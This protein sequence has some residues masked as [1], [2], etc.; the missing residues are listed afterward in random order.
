M[1]ARVS[2]SGPFTVIAFTGDVD[3][4]H[5][6]EARRQILRQVQGGGD[7]L[8]DLSAVEYLDSSG[9]ATLVEGF[10]LARERHQTFG[11]AGVSPS[12]MQVLHLA[13]LDQVFVIRD[14]IGDW[15]EPGTAP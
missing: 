8:I 15:L 12:A 9:V 6:P 7:V 13:R 3:L 1:E 5:A 10:Q 14:S 4:Q 2:S 11:L